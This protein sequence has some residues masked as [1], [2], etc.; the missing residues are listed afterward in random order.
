MPIFKNC[1][2]Q[3]C[4]RCIFSIDLKA[5]FRL[6]TG[7]MPSLLIILS[8][9]SVISSCLFL[10]AHFL[11]LLVSVVSSSG[12]VGWLSMFQATAPVSIPVGPELAG[13]GSGN[14]IGPGTGTGNGISVSWQSP[15]VI[16]KGVP[17]S[18]A[19]SHGFLSLS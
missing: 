9:S 6:K 19:W 13:I 2:R 3:L 16:F 7:E 11:S 18:E 12:F 5:Y 10:S 8:I 15:P 1:H 14:G 17:V 4:S